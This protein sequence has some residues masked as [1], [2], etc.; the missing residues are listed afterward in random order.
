M[1]LRA[2]ASHIIN[3]GKYKELGQVL[4]IGASTKNWG[5][6]YTFGQNIG[7]NLNADKYIGLD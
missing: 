3:W 2:G 6:Y 7:S 1:I 4:R 5:R